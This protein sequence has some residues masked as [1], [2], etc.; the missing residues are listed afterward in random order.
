MALML[1]LVACGVLAGSA[2]TGCANSAPSATVPSG[3]QVVSFTATA[4]GASQTT[5]VTV[6]IN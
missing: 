6:K 3:S 5:Q 1:L 4:T 2:L